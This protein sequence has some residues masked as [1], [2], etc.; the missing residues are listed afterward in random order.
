MNRVESDADKHNVVVGNET[1]NANNDDLSDIVETE[2]SNQ[3]NDKVDESDESVMGK[4]VESDRI[5]VTSNDETSKTLFSSNLQM[6]K[7]IFAPG[8][9]TQAIMKQPN[10]HEGEQVSNQV[11][12]IDTKLGIQWGLVIRNSG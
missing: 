12:M 4:K 2:D 3:V 5:G 7:L 10:I 8:I 6:S 9:S 1:T 11:R